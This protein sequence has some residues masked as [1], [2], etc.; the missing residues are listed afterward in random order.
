MM[1]LQCLLKR[2]VDTNVGGRQHQLKY[3]RMEEEISCNAERQELRSNQ[4]LV[5]AEEYA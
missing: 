2:L 4:P 5:G 3:Q 1:R